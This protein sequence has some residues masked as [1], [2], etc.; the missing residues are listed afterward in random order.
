MNNLEDG[1]VIGTTDITN[2]TPKC[3]S[4]VENKVVVRHSTI[5]SFKDYKNYTME[6][7]L[8]SWN[9]ED[10][11]LYTIIS[12]SWFNN[13][14]WRVACKSDTDA[15]SL[16]EWAIC[17]VRQ[18][19][20][21]ECQTVYEDIMRVLSV[22]NKNGDLISSYEKNTWMCD[23]SVLESNIIY[24]R[25]IKMLHAGYSFVGIKE[26]LNTEE[27]YDKI[28]KRAYHNSVE[29][30]VFDC[31]DYDYDGSNNSEVSNNR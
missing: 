16:Y 31:K 25:R 15:V 1:C 14:E 18:L 20:A 11:M 17:K 26:L 4:G 29:Q 21:K 5:M 24:D 12:K 13:P 3:E 8:R 9:G 6:I 22:A 30:L 2:K 7:Q 28:M 19:Y 10:Q 27:E 23:M